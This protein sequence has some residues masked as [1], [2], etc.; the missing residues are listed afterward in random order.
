MKEYEYDVLVVGAGPGGSTAA[1]YAAMGGARTLLIEKRQDIGNPVRCG[2]GI[3]MDWLPKVGIEPRKEWISAQVKGA[4]IYSPSEKYVVTL[5]AE[6]AGNE[7]GYVIERDK[8][9][10]YLAALAARAG[11]DIWVK[12]PAVNL[13]KEDGEVRGA[14]VRRNGELVKVWA[15]VIIGADGF[16]SQVGRWAGIRTAL[17]E[18][19]IIP[20]VQ[21]RM[22]GIDYEEDFTHFYIGSCA[23]GGYVWIFPKGPDEANVGIGVTL[24]FLREPGEVKRY[25]DRF[26]ER[27]PGLAKGQPIEIVTGG[28]STNRPLESVTANR[29]MLVGDA[30]RMID[31]ITGGGIKNACLSGMYAGQVAVEALETGDF[32]RNFFGKYEELWR[33][34]FETKN[35]RNWHAK[36][37]LMT[38]SD[39]DLEKIVEVL[40]EE[41]IEDISALSLFLA[42]QRRYPELVRKFEHLL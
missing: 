24:K 29:V 38:L 36:E 12:S 20:C 42:I 5:T 9:D 37:V 25:L 22:V 21:Y 34:E 26:I 4:K 16:E 13:I 18:N 33:R 3:S 8:F 14:V 1:R 32:S 31:P 39:E 10:K 28:V 17:S 30:A 7:V 6:H 23:P 41:D 27:H 2:E 35:L 15:K 11:A 40:S 19:D